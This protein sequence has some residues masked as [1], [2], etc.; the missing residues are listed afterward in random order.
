MKRYLITGAS[1]GIGRAIAEKLAE[2]N[3]TL[4]LHGRDVAALRET[5]NL[6]EA[7]GA[8]SR[9]LRADL[10]DKSSVEA[11]IEQVSGEP[12]DAL[13]NNAGIA[14][15]KPLDKI[16]IEEWERTFAINVTA[17]FLLSQGLIPAMGR[18][19]SI[20]NI[21]S[22]AAKAGFAGWS[23]YCMSKFALEGFSQAIR[24]ELRARKIRVINIYPA[25]TDTD[26]WNAVE[27]ERPREKMISAGQ[28]ASAVA[29]ALAQPSD[30]LIENITVGNLSG[31]L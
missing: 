27:G 13:I 15:V 20:V 26:I 8:I 23:S 22:I 1:R 30:V 29:Y 28:V 25:A 10:G 4:F 24:E 21:L 18:G 3:V 12:L 11:L 6:V 7:K 5:T 16:S 19:G 17:P 14:V 31:S 9:Q 2:S